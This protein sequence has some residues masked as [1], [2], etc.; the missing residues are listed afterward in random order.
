MGA[1]RKELT[2]LELISEL[3]VAM[4]EVIAGNE[5]VPGLPYLNLLWALHGPTPPTKVRSFYTQ[6]PPGDAQG[7]KAR[8]FIAG[9]QDP[10]APG[11]SGEELRIA[12]DLKVVA[13]ELGRRLPWDALVM[14]GALLPFPA[15]VRGEVTAN[16]AAANVRGD[17][18]TYS[19]VQW[20][21]RVPREKH[22]TIIVGEWPAVEGRPA[23]KFGYLEHDTF[24]Y[25]HDRGVIKTA[26]PV[27]A[28]FVI[29]QEAED[30]DA[31]WRQ[32]GGL[33]VANS[34][35]EF[36]GFAERGY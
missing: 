7:R 29:G 32:L 27:L 36:L 21:A 1:E 33:V 25:D 24:T 13:S 5:R 30:L 16:M 22:G 34:T 28:E 31:A 11:L 26:K 19:L 15:D 23:G 3:P 4:Q 18:H 10:N 9:L 6:F 8:E 2:R 35:A 20:G 12:S 17:N 14:Q